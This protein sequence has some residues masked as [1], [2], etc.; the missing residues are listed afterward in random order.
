M[1]GSTG[2]TDRGEAAIDGFSE[3]EALIGKTK[4]LREEGLDELLRGWN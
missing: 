4:D 3:I 1:E 2:E